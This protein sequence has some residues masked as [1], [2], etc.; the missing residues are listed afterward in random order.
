MYWQRSSFWLRSP[1]AATLSLSPTGLPFLQLPTA[2]TV[3]SMEDAK[4][5]FLSSAFMLSS[6]LRACW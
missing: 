5:I 3:P 4:V 2:T 6:C 1:T